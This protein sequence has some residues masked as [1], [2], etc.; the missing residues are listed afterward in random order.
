V[1]YKIDKGYVHTAVEQMVGRLRQFDGEFP[2][3]K[4]ITLDALAEQ[5]ALCFLRDNEF[6]PQMTICVGMGFL[7]AAMQQI[8]ISGART[9]HDFI[10]APLEDD[11]KE[12]MH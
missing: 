8:A 9:L 11:T 6:D 10:T 7:H 12:V 3:D 1:N 5:I 4:V 2:D